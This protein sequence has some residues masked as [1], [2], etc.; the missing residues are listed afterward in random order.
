MNETRRPLVAGNWKMNG[1]RATT[2]TLIGGL[3]ER[4]DRGGKPGCEIVICPPAPYLVDAAD[5][6]SGTADIGLGAQ[7]CHVAASGTH[8]GD[9]AASMLRD[10]GCAYVIVGHSERRSDHGETDLLVK[11]K[12]EA[13]IGAGL[14]AIVCIGETLAERNAGRAAEIVTGQLQASLAGS[15]GA[16]NTVI[17]Y[18]PV[19]AIGTGRTPTTEDIADI[20]QRIR[21]VL[22]QQLDDGDAVRILYGGSV[23]PDN[24][25]AI[26]A[27]AD[28]DGALV[29]GASLDADDFWA[30][31][32]S[33]R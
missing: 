9:I 3:A 32:R 13:A 15:A 4:L 19:W 17:A 10:V 28:V 6:L 26:L 29:G 22:R 33:S 1:A 20:H 27:V 16:A 30:I 18:E 14:S 12:A 24:A 7:D 2:R 5:A 21:A 31:C 11:A 8:T 23:K 25:A